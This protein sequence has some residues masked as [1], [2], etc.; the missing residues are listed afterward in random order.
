MGIT[1]FYKEIKL[2]YKEA[3]Y[4]IDQETYEYLY[5]DKKYTLQTFTDTINADIIAINWVMFGSN[6][7]ENNP[8]KYKC[9]IPTFTKSENKI[10]P[11]FKLLIRITKNINF[12][13]DTPHTIKFI[14]RNILKYTNVL[15]KP[16]NGKNV[17]E[18][19]GPKCPS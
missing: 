12:I 8:H 14:G 19:I 6:N 9:L 4:L 5:I 7:M 17:I 10:N 3:F 13:F 2:K 15:G 11:H 16:M 18:F 1:N